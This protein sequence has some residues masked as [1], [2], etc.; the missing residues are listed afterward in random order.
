MILDVSV[1]YNLAAEIPSGEPEDFYAECDSSETVNA[2]KDALTSKEHDVTLIEADENAY[3]K[4][5]TLK[6]DIV[7]NIAEGIRGE[8]RESQIPAM[9]EMLGI[10]YTGS[11]PLT[12][13]VTLDK[14]KTKEVLS[15]YGIPNPRFK[16]YDKP[17]LSENGFP[18]PAIVKPVSEGSSKGIFEDSVV[19]THDEL[20]ERVLQRLETYRQPVL[21]EEFLPGREFT[22]AILGNDEANVLPIVEVVFDDLPQGARGIDS[23]EAKWLWDKPENSLD[24]IR[25]PADL[26]ETLT[27]EINR[28]AVKTYRA[29]GCRDWCR[30]DLRL[31][32]K[33][34]PNVLDVN[35]L[36]GMIA[37]P[38]ANSRFPAAARAA[39]LTYDETINTVLDHAIKRSPLPIK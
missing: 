4:L 28:V 15:Y 8:S 3:E 36:P 34:I 22:V 21:V 27:T 20:S 13:A 12:L 30:I 26:D 10:P 39:G 33:G 2:I 14:A 32:E 37:N 25:C 19:D 9:L 6:P 5:R 18:L 35:A 1:A 7:F 11:G 31:D 24:C 38:K 16:V 23:Y 29:L 17:P